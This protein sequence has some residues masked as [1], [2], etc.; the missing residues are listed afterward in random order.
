MTDNLDRPTEEH[1][2]AV[3]IDL[4]EEL[5]SISNIVEELNSYPDYVQHRILRYLNDRYGLPGGVS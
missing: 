3:D 1:L 4:N 5:T 2:P